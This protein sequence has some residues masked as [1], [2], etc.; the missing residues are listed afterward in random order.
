MHHTFQHRDHPVCK[1]RTE[2]LFLA[3]AWKTWP[4]APPLV[5]TAGPA[6]QLTL[7]QLRALGVRRISTDSALARAAFT[8]LH[9]AANDMLNKGS[10]AYAGV[11]LSGEVLDGVMGEAVE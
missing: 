6:A 7:A 5:Q 9:H 3:A 4:T 10:F 11:A 8:A 2:T 1:L